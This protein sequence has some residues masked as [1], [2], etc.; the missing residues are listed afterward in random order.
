[1]RC[2]LRML[3][4]LL[5]TCLPLLRAD[6]SATRPIAPGVTHTAQRLDAGPWEVRVLRVK[7]DAPRVRLDMA[8]GM[9]A[10]RGV[11]QISGI[12]ARETT[13]EDTVVAAVNA[14][15]FVMAGNP[16]AGLLSGMAVRNGELIMTPRK[17]PAFWIT[18]D[19][20]PHIGTLQTQGTLTL[21]AG[22]FAVA[23][24]NQPPAK[25]GVTVYTGAFGW[26]VEERCVAVRAVHSQDDLTLTPEGRWEAVVL[27]RIPPKSSREI[28][29]GELLLHGEGSAEG[30][31]GSLMPG[32]RVVLTL[33]TPGPGGKAQLAVGGNQIL[34]QGGRVLPKDDPK[35]PRHPRTIVGF[36]AKE[37]LLVTVDGRQRGWSV[38]MT[39]VEEARLMLRLGCTDALNLDGGGSTTCWVRG[40]V[41]NRP[42][43]GGQRKIANALLVRS[44]APH[45]PLARLTVE[46][47]SIIAV[48]RARAPLTLTATDLW[49]NPVD[50][51]VRALQVSVRRLTG[52]GWMSARLVDGALRVGG[53]PG[54]G[55]VRFSL[56]GVGRLAEVPLTIVGQCD[57]LKLTPGVVQLCAGETFDLAA[58][59]LMKDGSRVWLPPRSAKWHVSGTGITAL[60]E[61]RF[62]ADAP[63][64][65]ATVRAT[66]GDAEGTAKVQVVRDVA[67]ESFEG[68]PELKV[69]VFPETEGVVTAKAEVLATDAGEGERFARLTYDLG[70]ANGTRAAYLRLDRDLGSALRLSALTRGTASSPAWLRVAVIDGNGTRQTYTVADAV[71]WS[72]DWRRVSVRLPDGLKQPLKWESVY[73]VVLDG[74]T[75]RGTLDVD[76]LRAETAD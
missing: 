68:A 52:R 1:M 71:T 56:P 35:A 5:L 32:D 60:G 57:A 50:L 25:D 67:V 31:V 3:L 42:S 34:L 48:S 72:K 53:L 8:L 47:Q 24:I 49:Y 63:G 43:D 14:D 15:F 13:R 21:E 75:G 9:G 18:T 73:V 61:G 41:T 58:Q 54:T 6:E 4:P 29:P 27:E 44:M 39:P 38:G 7:R 45:G 74:K 66:L 19:G 64:S 65:Q 33:H 23:G 2:R 40:A 62:R 17:R 12:V 36:N 59:G 10:L 28:V 51:D 11:E 26:P 46:P 70:T 69:T 20:Q 16:N 76:D 22:E 55:T 30:A 37:V